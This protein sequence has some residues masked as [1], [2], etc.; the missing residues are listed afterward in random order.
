MWGQPLEFFK[1]I[2]TN[3]T[4]K[5]CDYTRWHVETNF[6]LFLALRAPVCKVQ[7]DGYWEF[8]IFSVLEIALFCFYWLL[9]LRPLLKRGAGSTSSLAFKGTNTKTA[10]IGSYP[11]SSYKF[12]QAIKIIC[13]V[14]WAKILYFFLFDEADIIHFRIIIFLVGLS[15]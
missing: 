2:I 8:L 11:K 6:S 4:Y 7:S 10:R 9:K 3:G 14:F 1:L 5:V 12:E 15:L 13:W